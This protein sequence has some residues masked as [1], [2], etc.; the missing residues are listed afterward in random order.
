VHAREAE[1]E[2]ADIAGAV[3]HAPGDNADA[4]ARAGLALARVHRTRVVHRCFVRAG[5]VGRSFVRARVLRRR[6]AVARVFAAGVVRDGIVA[7]IAAGA[8]GILMAVGC[9][10]ER[11]ES[12]FHDEAGRQC[13]RTCTIDGCT[14]DCDTVTGDLPPLQ[15]ELERIVSAAT[16]ARNG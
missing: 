7:P 13:V 6:F 4:V 9:R 8:L 16:T 14:F 2:I 3:R 10:D 1:R 11:V 5:V 15:A 12:P